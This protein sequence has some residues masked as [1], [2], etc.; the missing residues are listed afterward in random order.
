MYTRRD[1]VI[2]ALAHRPPRW[3]PWS[4][5]FTSEARERLEGHFGPR[6]EEVLDPHVAWVGSAD[7]AE[8]LPGS[9]V[10]DRWGVVWD[11][12][13]DGDIGVVEGRLLPEPDLSL[14]RLPDPADP[15]LWDGLAA[16]CAANAGRYRV[17][18]IGFSLWERA[19]TLRGMEEL[20]TDLADA[21]E[22]VEG[23]LDAIADWNIAVARRALEHDI[24]AVYFGDDWGSQR[25]LLTGLRSWRR[26]VLPR[27]RRMYGA[28]RG[29]G[30][31]V[32]IHSCGDVDELFPDLVEA[33]VTCF[34]P[35]QPEVMDVHA[36]AGRWHGR[37]AF[38]GGLSTQRT[39][40][41]GS[42]AEVVAETGALL[43]RGA[44]GGYLF[45]PAHAVEGDVPL[46][47]LLA[48]IDRVRDQPGYRRL[49]G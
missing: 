26:F 5:W 4:M 29:A 38:H 48:M 19:W 2:D 22:F 14:L 13:K 9:R 37:L 44:G 40:P 46:E 31:Q 41:Y 21:P 39:L 7:L 18:G 43:A 3:V 32:F 11:R 30:R 1:A 36:L 24:D 35:F 17:F 6:T 42:A 27:I 47:N 16:R 8:P 33:G 28:V 20:M 12:S 23:L 25:G 45:A 34:N 49:A 10:R 15:R